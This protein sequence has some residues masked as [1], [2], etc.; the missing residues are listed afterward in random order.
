MVLLRQEYRRQKHDPNKGD[1]HLQGFCRILC[2][3]IRHSYQKRRHQKQQGRD[4]DMQRYMIFKIYFFDLPVSFHGYEAS[5]FFFE[6][7]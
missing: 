3:K 2:P 6:N 5:L 4:Q 7:I 1:I